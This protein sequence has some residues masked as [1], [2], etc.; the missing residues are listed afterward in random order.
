MKNFIYHS[1]LLI[2]NPLEQ[3]LDAELNKYGLDGWEVCAMQHRSQPYKKNGIDHD[4][5][6]VTF[7]KDGS[8]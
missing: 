5:Y 3:D 4:V 7:K 6:E 8:V 2:I 1:I